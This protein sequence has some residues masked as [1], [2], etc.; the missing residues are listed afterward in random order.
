M[1]KKMTNI[2]TNKAKV[3]LHEKKKKQNYFGRCFSHI[4]SVI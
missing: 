4:L 3:V 2:Q 1:T